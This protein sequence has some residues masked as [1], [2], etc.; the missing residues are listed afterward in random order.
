MPISEGKGP[1]VS[2]EIN[3]IG[4]RVDTTNREARIVVT[5]VNF[6]LVGQLCTK[7]QWFFYPLSV[8]DGTRGTFQLENVFGYTEVSRY[9]GD[10]LVG[11]TT[12]RLETLAGIL[13][14]NVLDC[15]I[16]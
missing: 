9:G 4:F 14:R 13:A 15:S 1:I 10:G 2:I 3:S 12:N 8:R 7:V 16:E 5:G 6:W 11:L